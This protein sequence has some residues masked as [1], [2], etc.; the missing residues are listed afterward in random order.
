MKLCIGCG[1]FKLDGYINIDNRKEVQ[2]DLVHDITNPLP[3]EDNL[4]DEIYSRHVIEHFYRNVAIKILR[5]WYRALKPTGK[6]NIIVPNIDY[7]ARQLVGQVSN[8]FP[9][10]VDHAMAGFYGWAT[11]H[12]D[13]NQHFWGYTETSLTIVL[14]EIG[15]K[16]VIRMTKGKDVALWHLNL[17]GEK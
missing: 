11:K 14:K 17:V 8:P 6:L 12:S 2:P 3:Y 5:D 9:N 10:Q 7:H 15:F 1:D 13:A 4:I 16:S